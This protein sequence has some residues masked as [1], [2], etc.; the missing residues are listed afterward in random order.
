MDFRTGLLTPP[1]T[2]DFTTVPDN[3]NC[4]L[5]CPGCPDGSRQ[6]DFANIILA[7]YDYA[8][9]SQD[10]LYNLRRAVFEQLKIDDSYLYMG[11]NNDI[12]LQNFF[13]DWS[14]GNTGLLS[15][16]T[17]TLASDSDSLATNIISNISPNNLAEENE[18]IVLEIYN[19]TWAIDVYEFSQSQEQTLYDIATQ[20]PITGGTAVYIARAMLDM[21]VDD[22]IVENGNRIGIHNDNEIILP[23]EFESILTENGDNLL[24]T[25][26]SNSLINEVTVITVFGQTVYKKI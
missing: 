5:P 10:E 8:N 26:K 25:E 2:Y 18:K 24:V 11:T 23:T 19:V 15:N 12:V 22:F 6:Q 1:L 21:D 4:E 17:T 14:T 3:T 16:I 13:T 20:N 7:L 9:L